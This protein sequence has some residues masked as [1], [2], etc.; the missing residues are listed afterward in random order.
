MG[1]ICNI[2][3]KID[4]VI[5]MKMFFSFFLSFERQMLGL[6]AFRILKLRT[7]MLA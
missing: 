6:K 1:L 4:R 3:C 2:D 5:R 7:R